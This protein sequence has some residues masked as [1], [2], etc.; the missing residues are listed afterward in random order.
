MAQVKKPETRDA[1]LNA[2]FKLFS[3]SGYVDTT[4][5]QI[6]SKAG[7]STSNF[8]S[9]FNSK[10]HVLYELHEPWL[11]ARLERL[12][13]ELRRLRSPV[14]KIERLLHTLWCEIPRENN[15]FAITFIQ[16]IAT[17]DPTE[18]YRPGLLQWIEQRI[19]GMLSE[20]VRP[21]QRDY[22][23]QT[24]V[25]HV[26]M[27]SFDG[28]VINHHLHPSARCDEETIAVFAALLTQQPVQRMPRR[29]PAVP[30]VST[31]LLPASGVS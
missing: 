31:V 20:C 16:A 4:I 23:R 1:I 27:M 3:S 10:L 12:E 25:A 26:L 29:R 13:I 19:A 14:R 28:Y 6:A 8:Y 2:A 7:V 5:A 21:E 22:L 11:K 17:V 30:D 9:Y 18:G 24:R 15:G